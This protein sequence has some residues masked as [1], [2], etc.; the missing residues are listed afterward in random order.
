VV[1]TASVIRSLKSLMVITLAR[2][3]EGCA[4]AFAW[5]TSAA[6][7]AE[8]ADTAFDLWN[9]DVEILERGG[10]MFAFT[11]TFAL[12]GASSTKSA[13]AEDCREMVRTLPSLEMVPRGFFEM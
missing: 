7:L 8:P 12:R 6:R 10:G 1:F 11:P 3:S 13:G 9:V 5:A 2:R 4:Q